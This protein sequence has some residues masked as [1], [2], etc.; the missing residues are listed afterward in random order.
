MRSRK[1]L[2]M[3][4]TQLSKEEKSWFSRMISSLFSLMT[5]FMCCVAVVLSGQIYSAGGF[6]SV[7]EKWNEVSNSLNL[8]ELKEWIFLEKW[9]SGQVLQVSANSYQ[10]IENQMYEVADHEVVAVDDGIVI[11][12]AE[13][14]DSMMVMV[15]QDN[16]LIVTYGQLNEVFCNEDD[17]VVAGTVLGKVHDQ[18][19]LDFSWQGESISYEEA[20][21]F[22]N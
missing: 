12:C 4:R 5:L 8:K 10:L 9:I 15:R 11:Y 1:D 2:Y 21:A 22:E 19:Y 16:G 17:R 20:T 6:D 3:R 7:V 13:Q 14:N 18:V